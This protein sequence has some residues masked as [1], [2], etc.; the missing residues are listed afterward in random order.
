MQIEKRIVK[1]K[2]EYP[3]WG[4]LEIRERLR[5]QCPELLV[6]P[7]AP[8]TRCWIVTAWSSAGRRRNGTPLPTKTGDRCGQGL[9]GPAP[10]KT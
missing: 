8:C 3:H 7:S 10:S 6:R 9:G 4:A 1:L 5:R 2:K